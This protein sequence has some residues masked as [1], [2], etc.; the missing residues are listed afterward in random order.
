MAS[1]F[2][3]HL[4]DLRDLE[5]KFRAVAWKLDGQNRV[6]VQSMSCYPD[7]SIGPDGL[8]EDWVWEPRFD[9]THPE[10]QELALAGEW[11]I[12]ADWLELEHER[13]W[14]IDIPF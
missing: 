1:L 13:E 10:G 4:R 9:L 12:L 7:Y 2:V 8:R 11:G 3:W 5:V 6:T 14:L